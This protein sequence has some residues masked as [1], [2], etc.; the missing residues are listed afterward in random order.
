[1]KPVFPMIKF[2]T[3]GGSESRRYERLRTFALLLIMA[4]AVFVRFRLLLQ[5]EHN[6][7]HAYPVWQALMT[8][9]HGVFPLVG[10]QTSV[11]F[12]NPPLTGYLFLPFVA[13][14]RS[15][16][17]PY[18][19]VIPLNIMGV[20]LAY[21]AMRALVGADAALIGAALMAVN[22][23]VIEYSRTSWV[24]SLLPFL[25]PA[26]AWALIPVVLRTARHPARRTIIAFIILT[27]LAHTYL[28]G[29]AMIIPVA[30][31]LI[32]F[33]KRIQWRAV[34]VGAAIFVFAA[35]LY[36]IGL[37][38]QRDQIAARVETFASEPPRL[39]AEAWTHAVRLVTGADYEIARGAQAPIQ[40]S[41][42]RHSLSLIAHNALYV[43]LMVGLVILLYRA[44][45]HRDDRAII[46]VVWFLA[47]IVLMSYV[48]QVI[49]PFYQLL[50]LPMGYALVGVGIV[51]CLRLLSIK[52]QGFDLS[53][54]PSPTS[55][56]GASA[57]WVI[58]G[59]LVAHGGLMAVN[60]SRYYEETAA[61]PGVHGLSALSLAWG[62]RLGDEIRALLP[63]D[64]TVYSDLDA[65]Y[66][67]SSFAGQTLDYVNFP[68]YARIHAETQ[69]FPVNG[70]IRVYAFTPEIESPALV[71]DDDGDRQILLPD[72]SVLAVDYV[73]DA[74]AA[75][76]IPAI[77]D[78]LMS[79]VTTDQGLT[80][81]GYRLQRNPDSD[82][83]LFWTVWRVVDR[84]QD[85]ENR[86]FQWFV[87]VFD[88]SGTRIDIL[89]MQAVPTA[90]WRVGELHT[91]SMEIPIPPE[92]F[93]PARIGFGLYDPN[94]QVNAIFITS[95]GEY[96]PMIMLPE[97][98]NP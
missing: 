67:L 82:R 95:E 38:G 45:K 22:P 43:A 57:S 92:G 26:L 76:D 12:G 98:L 21:R 80:L 25:V 75:V 18:L 24:Q 34:A 17:A 19:L 8:L 54:N 85:I 56:R 74:E 10:Q 91:L 48:G 6:V 16:L 31:L 2:Y 32:M 35:V 7:D 47:P 11:L 68:P 70:G 44:V 13:L 29:Y 3:A 62:I 55:A 53:P 14:I 97:A 72:A 71:F 33:R 4:V 61:I 79:D 30:F 5:I 86:D 65:P 90:L 9:D 58:V 87:H 36:G 28:L 52:R 40:D 39:S 73:W 63:P 41:V 84:L 59:L 77:R 64:G 83:Y 15:P 51:A 89:D 27:I 50:G 94:A 42:L 60:S 20:L 37:I 81:I 69:I 49:H 46:V 1:M 78:S 88:S 66:I 96:T 23:W 93:P